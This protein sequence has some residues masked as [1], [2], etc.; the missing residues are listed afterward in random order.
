MPLNESRK[1]VTK[2]ALVKGPYAKMKIVTVIYHIYVMILL[3]PLD[4]F[5]VRCHNDFYFR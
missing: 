2:T 4:T 5:A 3:C 1:M